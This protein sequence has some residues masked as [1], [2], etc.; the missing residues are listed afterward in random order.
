M[1]LEQ[2]IDSLKSKKYRDLRNT[3]TPRKVRVIGK[4]ILVEGD[5]LGAFCWL[6]YASATLCA[7]RWQT[8]SF[9]TMLIFHERLFD[10]EI[11]I[12]Y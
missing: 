2:F 5:V 8:R 3:L 7:T 1:T 10:C 12:Y 9:L 6:C 11:G 4:R